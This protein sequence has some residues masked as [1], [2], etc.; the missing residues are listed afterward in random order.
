MPYSRPFAAILSGTL[1]L[2]APAGSDEIRSSVDAASLAEDKKTGLGLY[3]TAQDAHRALSADPDIVFI[4]VRDPN[5]VDFVGHPSA[6]DAIVPLL[7]A[8]REYVP[9]ARSYSMT[10]NDGFVAQVATV[11][12]REGAGVDDP[13]FVICRSGARGADAVAMLDRAGYENV[14]N[15]VHG[16]QGDP[17][18]DG[19]RDLNGWRTAGLPWTYDI[20]PQV[21][22]TQTEPAAGH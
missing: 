21:A 17:G 20:A 14:W 10:P 16:F 1:A 6:I 8:T 5:E 13:I 3:L 15:V 22:W 18:A 2:A 19:V 7:L 11:L 4:D 12:D 9:Q